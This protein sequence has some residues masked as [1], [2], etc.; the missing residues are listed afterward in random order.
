M[1]GGVTSA[2]DVGILVEINGGLEGSIDSEG[3]H[4]GVNAHEVCKGCSSSCGTIRNCKESEL[5]KV[6]GLENGSRFICEGISV[7]GKLVLS[8]DA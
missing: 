8:N 7:T 2:D 3:N 5:D 1:E 4:Y 6:S